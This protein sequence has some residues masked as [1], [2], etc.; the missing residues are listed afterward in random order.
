[1]FGAQCDLIAFQRAMYDVR[2][3]QEVWTAEIEYA[4][5]PPK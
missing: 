5:G 4:M 2:G 1:M 3:D